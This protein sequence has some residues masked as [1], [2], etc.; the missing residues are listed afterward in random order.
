MVGRQLQLK[1]QARNNVGQTR[2]MQVG[3]GEKGLR[4]PWGDGRG[5]AFL[6]LDMLLAA[7]IKGMRSSQLGAMRAPGGFIVFS[8]ESG[9][10]PRIMDVRRSNHGTDGH[11]AHG[12]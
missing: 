8:L 2:A 3:L 1:F 12:M 11:G 10:R 4:V 7:K 9:V 5:E 6:R